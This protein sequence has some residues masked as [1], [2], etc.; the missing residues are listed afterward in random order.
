MLCDLII[1]A[2]GIKSITRQIVVGHPDNAMKTGD[3]AYRAIISTEAMMK[4]ED[5]RP[6]VE[7]PE[8]TGW[9]GPGRHIVGYCIVGSNSIVYRILFIG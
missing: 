1:G 6:L 2:D 5:L 7:V 3:A 9:L 4:D 8:M